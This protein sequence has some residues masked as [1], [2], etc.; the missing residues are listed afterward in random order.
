[1]WCDVGKGG[2]STDEF[3][4]NSV[5]IVKYHGGT[6]KAPLK[7]GQLLLHKQTSVVVGTPTWQ[8]SCLVGSTL[9]GS[10]PSALLA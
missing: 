2:L 10:M 1:M 5:L 8:S 9:T 4:C 7:S 6:A 3:N